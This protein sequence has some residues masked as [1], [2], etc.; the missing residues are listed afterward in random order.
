MLTISL[1]ALEGALLQQMETQSIAQIFPITPPSTPAK[2]KA[3][4]PH[5]QREMLITL[6]PDIKK[7]LTPLP[8][9]ESEAAH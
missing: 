7:S 2:Q 5:F 3:Q 9:Q 8:P 1:A 6:K 4:E